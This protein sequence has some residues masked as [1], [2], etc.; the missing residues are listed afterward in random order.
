MTIISV[1]K[2]GTRNLDYSAYGINKLEV[3]A[4]C[5]A[6]PGG[7]NSRGQFSS[8]FMSGI[9]FCPAR[10]AIYSKITHVA[11]NGIAT[12]KGLKAKPRILNPTH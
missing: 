4:A 10:T 9:G 8:F 2:E 6:C 12:L 7:L 5:N 1:I 11:V 3:Q